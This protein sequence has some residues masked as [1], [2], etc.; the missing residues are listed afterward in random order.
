MIDSSWRRGWRGALV[1]VG[2]GAG[3]AFAFQPFGIEPLMPLAFALLFWLIADTA[4]LW[5]ALLVG[6]LFGLGQFC[7]G[8]NWIATAFTFQAA[9]PAWLGWLAVFLLSLYL[10][11]YPMLA[12]ALGWTFGRRSEIAR[13][14]ALAGAWAL[15]E[16]LRATM[17]TGF[18]WNP[19]AAASV[20][21]AAHVV[22]LVGTYGAS[23]LMVLL[24]GA[25][26]LLGRWEVRPLLAVAASGLLLAVVAPLTTRLLPPRP[27]TLRIVQSNIGQEQRWSPAAA[28]QSERRLTALSMAPDLP[29]P[30]LLFWPE[31]AITEPLEDQRRGAEPFVLAQRQTAAA[32]L[33]PRDLLMAGGIGLLSTDG[34]Q[35][36]GGVNSI[37]VL[38]QGGREIGRYDKAHLVPYGEYL[39]MRPLLSAIGLSRLAPG[40]LDY[41]SGPG[42]ATIAMPDGLRVGF[43]LC[44]EMIFSG[45]V[46]DRRHRPEVIFNPS[47]DAWF[48]R[49]G[50]PQHLAQAR[51]RAAEEGLPVIRS[52]PTGI[53]ALVDAD[54]RLLRQIGWKQAGVITAPLP[55]ARTPTLFAMTGNLL[56]ILLGFA[57]L[58][59]AIVIDRGRRYRA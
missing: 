2:A 33:G 41:A 52:T 47:N 49:W 36:S 30:F 57:L 42:P 16:Y 6:W 20:P 48:G 51:L 27:E 22:P 18:A 56:P 4:S 37:F 35:V 23:A 53:S 3:S 5:R 8:L 34:R 38:G 50:P 43:Q 14:L 46:V 1:A 31:S 29:S 26:F 32:L 19:V 9:M 12:V 13:M 59:G 11:V 54:G 15:C 28:G 44:Y 55:P 24:G 40:D 10:A 7:I 39:P 17:F 21:V 25:L 45:E 58:I